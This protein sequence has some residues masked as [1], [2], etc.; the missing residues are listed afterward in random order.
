[1]E[2][3]T[4]NC[5]TGPLSSPWPPWPLAALPPWPSNLSTVLLCVRTSE[6]IIL[7][8][9]DVGA[10]R[11]ALGTTE[12]TFANRLLKMY[13][14]LHCKDFPYKIYRVSLFPSNLHNHDVGAG[15]YV[16]GTTEIT[17]VN[18]LLK[19]YPRLHCKG[20]L[21]KIYR[22][23]LLPNILTNHD[24][25]GGSYNLGTTEITLHIQ[26]TTTLQIFFP[27]TFNRISYVPISSTMSENSN[28][29]TLQMFSQQ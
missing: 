23:S 22:D 3:S 6:E 17:F 1:M 29:T 28:K 5:F 18:Q 8:N 26:A 14:R 24:V 9:H 27:V 19:M 21:Y 4:T 2:E 11:Y 16:L 13:P 20:F 25:G 10:G 15:R 7:T 12:T